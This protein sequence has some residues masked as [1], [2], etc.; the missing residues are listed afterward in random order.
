MPKVLRSEKVAKTLVRLLVRLLEFNQEQCEAGYKARSHLRGEREAVNGSWRD[1]SPQRLRD[2]PRPSRASTSIDPASEP[3]SRAD[4]AMRLHRHNRTAGR[5]SL[6]ESQ[7][8]QKSA[9]VV[10]KYGLRL[11]PELYGFLNPMP[12]EAAAQMEKDLAEDLRA[13]GYTVTGGT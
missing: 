11:M 3:E 9:W 13:A 1:V 12:F 2:S 4:K 7:E 5:A 6:R 10:R 8:G